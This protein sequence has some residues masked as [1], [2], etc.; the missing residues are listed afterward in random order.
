MKVLFF[1][2]LREQLGT[3]EISKA[4][5]EG[6]ET[7]GQLLANLQTRSDQWGQVLAG[8]KLLFAVNQD[9]VDESAAI[10]D[11]DEVALFPPVTGG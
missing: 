4:L 3:G 10:S 5:P 7:V 8:S 1:G 6:V 2:S 9:M 11:G